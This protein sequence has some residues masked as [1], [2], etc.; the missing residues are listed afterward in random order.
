VDGIEERSL[1]ETIE[2]F[3][4]GG[5]GECTPEKERGQSYHL[6]SAEPEFGRGKNTGEKRGS[7]PNFLLREKKNNNR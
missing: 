6:S 7:K 2:I 4:D 3:K 5:N 1:A